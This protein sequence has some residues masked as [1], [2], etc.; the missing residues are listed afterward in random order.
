MS[1]EPSADWR[2]FVVVSPRVP[3]ALLKTRFVEETVPAVTR[4]V[5]VMF[6]EETLV[7]ETLFA[8]KL[9]VVSL[10]EETL[11]EETFVAARL[12]VVI[13]V[14]ET[15]VEETLEVIRRLTVMLPASVTVPVAETANWV[16]EFTWKSMKFPT[17]VEE[18]LEPM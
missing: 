4:F 12:A 18:G 1:K 3:E 8:A 16:D 11:V 15:F 6:V 17:K 13:L 5:T 9:P 7:E 14:E 10:V 2:K